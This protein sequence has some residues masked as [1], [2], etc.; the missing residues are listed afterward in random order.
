MKAKEGQERL[1]RRWVAREPP[2][3]RPSGAEVPQ[4]RADS[5]VEEVEGSSWEG[6][7][8]EVVQQVEGRW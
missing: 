2:S 7:E 8:L 1:V 3:P 6:A 4:R 5:G